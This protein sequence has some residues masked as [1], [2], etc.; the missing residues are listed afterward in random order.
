MMAVGDDSARESVGSSVQWQWC[1]D[2]LQWMPYSSSSTAI[3]ESAFSA[4][5]PFV[6]LQI[7]HA[8]Y[9]VSFQPLGPRQR[10]LITGCTR[11][12]RRQNM[13]QGLGISWQWWDK[14]RQK[15]HCYDAESVAQIE[16]K[17]MKYKLTN[18]QSEQGGLAGL[19]VTIRGYSYAIEFDANGVQ[20]NIKTHFARAVRRCSN[21]QSNGSCSDIV[22]G[23]NCIGRPSSSK[24]PTNSLLLH[25]ANC[26]PCVTP[27]LSS[28][29]YSVA[30][31]SGK[32]VYND[33]CFIDFSSLSE[34]KDCSI[35]LSSLAEQSAVILAKCKHSFHRRCIE[36]W[37]MSR[38]SCPECLTVYGIIIGSQPP[39]E[40]H[41]Q[42]ISYGSEE[43]KCGLAGYPNTDVI[44][45]MYRFPSGIQTAEHPTPGKPYIGT[46]RVAYLP[47]NK[48]G[49]EVL[50]LLKKAWSRRLLF[51]VGTS[52]TTGQSDVV[53]WSGIHH[54]TR[55]TGGSSNHGYPDENY[56]ERVKK[57][58]ADVGV[59]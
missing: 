20:Y 29:V 54:K 3:I 22:Q 38:P 25:S 24:T 14:E 45:I 7:S 5:R 55:M 34:S 26:I 23:I 49:E 32:P 1:T 9:T 11:P 44:K 37:F 46:L 51:R 13:E 17:W 40:M 18:I 31:S 42:I 30:E 35:C 57:E 19:F 41:V 58:L 53:V 27:D 52:V 16:E 50:D 59:I 4:G 15:W 21:L 56:F 10:N 39:G 36:L 33:E 8:A 43:A 48:D 28:P 6:C 12:I 2:S 47:R